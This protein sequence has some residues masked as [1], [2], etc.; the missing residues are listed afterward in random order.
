MEAKKPISS[1]N[2]N[3]VPGRPALDL[4]LKTETGSQQKERSRAE[5]GAG[6]QGH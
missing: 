6:I 1:E 2:Q 4:G 5:G 3:Q